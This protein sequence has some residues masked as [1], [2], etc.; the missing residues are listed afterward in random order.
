MLESLLPQELAAGGLPQ[1]LAV[2]AIVA[3]SAVFRGFT[4]FGFAVIAVP[5][6]SLAMPPLLA[7]TLAAGLQFLGG[8]MDVRQVAPLAHWASVRWLAL[9]AVLASPLGTLLLT[10]LPADIARLVLAAACGA[11]VATLAAGYGFRGLPGRAVTAVTGAVSGLF[12]GLASMPGPPALAYYLASPLPSV[13]IRASLLVFFLLSAGLSSAS[14][15]AIGVV[16][17]HELGL[18]LLGLPLMLGGSRLGARLFA[19]LGG[20]HRR[21]SLITLALVALVTAFRG[22]AGLLH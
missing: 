14:L 16:G 15:V 5:L 18:V 22:V 20:A 8:L 2:V 17:W 9:G 10:W 12:N 21:V 19:R 13:Q 6:L 11:A 1:L 4:G 3:G 7:V